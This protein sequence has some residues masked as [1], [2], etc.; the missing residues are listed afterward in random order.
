MVGF[1]TIKYERIILCKVFWVIEIHAFTI[2]KFDSKEKQRKNKV[3]NTREMD[4]VK[5][6]EM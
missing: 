6:K 4:T 3:H 5:Q 2:I 1:I